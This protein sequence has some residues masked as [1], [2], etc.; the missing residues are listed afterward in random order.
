MGNAAL[1]LFLSMKTSQCQVTKY[2]VK[3]KSAIMGMPLLTYVFQC[4][5]GKLRHNGFVALIR[6]FFYCIALL[7]S[8]Q[9]NYLQLTAGKLI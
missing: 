9:D 5:Y 8:V 3:V 2:F 7:R 1:N 6:G 4:L